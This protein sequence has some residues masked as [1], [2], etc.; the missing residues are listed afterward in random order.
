MAYAPEVLA[1]AFGDLQEDVVCGDEALLP[2]LEGSL[3]AS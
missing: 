3:R 2:H 1:N